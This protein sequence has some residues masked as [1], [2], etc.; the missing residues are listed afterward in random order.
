MDSGNMDSE[1]TD[2]DSPD[3]LMMPRKYLSKDEQASFT[4]VAINICKQ[5]AEIKN[6]HC[7]LLKSLSCDNVNEPEYNI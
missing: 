2:A 7:P 4:L 5:H 3:R 6:L 1:I